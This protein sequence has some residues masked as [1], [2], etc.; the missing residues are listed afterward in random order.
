M[1]QNAFYC[2]IIID[3]S[4]AL[5]GN[6]LYPWVGILETNEGIFFLRNKWNC[7]L[8]IKNDVNVPNIPTFERLI[9]AELEVTSSAISRQQESAVRE[10]N[11]CTSCDPLAK[12]NL[13][14]RD[15]VCNS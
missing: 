4:A 1:P 5:P 9:K 14:C 15:V 7:V 12:T 13:I 11:M 8:T 6:Q 2:I 3:I 10:T